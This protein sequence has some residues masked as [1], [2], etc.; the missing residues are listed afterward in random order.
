MGRIDANLGRS[1]YVLANGWL[2]C[3]PEQ[4][5]G[6]YRKRYQLVHR[7]SSPLRVTVEQIGIYIV[8]VQWRRVPLDA[9]HAAWML[10]AADRP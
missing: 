8:C 3:T 1:N 5:S 6:A 10:F 4:S 7:N 2:S 9:K